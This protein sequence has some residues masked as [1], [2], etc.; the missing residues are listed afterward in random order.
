VA[1]YGAYSVA[2]VSLAGSALAFRRDRVVCLFMLLAIHFILL[3]G[4]VQASYSYYRMDSEILALYT[5]SVL[6]DRYRTDNL[7]L[8]GRKVNTEI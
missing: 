3:Y 4:L 6:W 8:L 5:L 7:R 1:A 2:L